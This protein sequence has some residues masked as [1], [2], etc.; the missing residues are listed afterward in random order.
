MSALT[1][2]HPFIGLLDSGIGGLSVLREVHRLLP[3]HPTLYYAD[4]SHLPYGPRPPEEVR[5]FVDS[6]T[7]FLLGQGA[8]VIVLA[9][10]AASAA[11]L[12]YLREHYPDVP[13]VGMEPAVKP[14]VEATRTGVVAVLTT[15]ATAAGPLY[16]RVLK[17]YAGDVNVL[18]QIA[19]EF[20][21][22]AEAQSQDTPAGRAVI[23]RYIEPLLEAGA[24]QIV[25]AC[26]HFPFLSAAI[27]EIAGASVTL[28][29]PAPAV[30][31]QVARLW[32]ANLDPS[33]TA[34][35]YF[36]SGDPAAFQVMLKTLINIDEPLSH[37]N[38]DVAGG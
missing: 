31:R 9:C 26:T 16:E 8:A 12:L 24:D 25:L 27:Q 2:A 1:S 11:S 15:G 33:P 28:I 36:T 38:R 5:Q 37:L 21:T 4:Q 22:I 10:N 23:R 29:D 34:N 3:N 6:I 19:P 13:F 20:V 7:R 30:A 32:P 35:R 17:R 18:T 14:A